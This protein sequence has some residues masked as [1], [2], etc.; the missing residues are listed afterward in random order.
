MEGCQVGQWP[1]LP[2]FSGGCFS[3][4]SPASQADAQLAL[5]LQVSGQAG[6]GQEK[7][8]T[9]LPSL[10][11]YTWPVFKQVPPGPHL[12]RVLLV[13]IHSA[14]LAQPQPSPSLP[15]GPPRIAQGWPCPAPLLPE[16]PGGCSW[17]LMC[18]L[19]PHHPHHPAAQ[20]PPQEP[21]APQRVKCG[22][23]T[24]HATHLASQHHLN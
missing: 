15:Q 12:L 3:R 6:T 18:F 5:G 13:S 21:P 1:G 24:P 16:P 20:P 2:T 10:G 4:K 11:H 8:P 22:S 17:G 7:L 14:A 19:T 9:Q 23:H